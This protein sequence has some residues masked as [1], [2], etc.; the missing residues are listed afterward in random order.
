MPISAILRFLP[1]C[2]SSSRA[3]A[4]ARSSTVRFCASRQRRYIGTIYGTHAVVFDARDAIA[5]HAPP[6]TVRA[7]PELR[8]HLSGRDELAREDVAAEQVVVHRFR[9]DLSDCIGF[10]LDEGVVF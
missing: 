10:E 3:S 2:R 9:D 7:D 1:S 5:G 8:V 6:A 4:C